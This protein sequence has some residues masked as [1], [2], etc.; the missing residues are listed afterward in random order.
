MKKV[1]LSAFICT[2]VFSANAEVIS[3]VVSEAVSQSNSL[4]G[5]Y[6]GVG[7]GGSFL[8]ASNMIIGYGNLGKKESIFKDFKVDRFM[9]SFVIGGGKIFNKT[10]YGGVEVLLDVMENKKRIVGKGRM[11]MK[12]IIPQI[13]VKA[14]YATDQNTTAYVKL[15]C[16]WSKASSDDLEESVEPNIKSSLVLGVGGEKVFH[17][18]F[19]TALEVDYNLGGRY[20]N[21]SEK[22]RINKGFH[23]RALVKYN[24]KV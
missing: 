7:G 15:G 11:K 3:E 19:S 5:I 21:I 1:I 13:D 23:L 16:A 22:T 20:A 10:V 6:A 8:K 24:V 18:R 17:N 14:G 9:G 2:I 4:D 12:G